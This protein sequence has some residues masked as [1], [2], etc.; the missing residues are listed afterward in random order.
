MI[1][2]TTKSPAFNG[3]KEMRAPNKPACIAITDKAEDKALLSVFKDELS[4]PATQIVG[5]EQEPAHL[6][7]SSSTALLDGFVQ[8]GLKGGLIEGVKKIEGLV[9][10]AKITVL[11]I[12][13]APSNVISITDKKPVT[14]LTNR[15]IEIIKDRG[16]YAESI[17]IGAMSKDRLAQ[18]GKNP[19]TVLTL[20]ETEAFVEA[21]QEKVDASIASCQSAPIGPITKASITKETNT[22]SPWDDL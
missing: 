13:Q 18:S 19:E 9:N 7:N 5:L 12:F 11:D 2:P 22:P 21:L 1:H 14:P 4:L 15:V 8:A 20:E 6:K 3:L 10:G 17:L 16:S